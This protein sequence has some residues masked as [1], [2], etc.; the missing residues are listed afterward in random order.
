MSRIW[1]E[2]MVDIE[3]E[4]EF[5]KSGSATGALVPD[6]DDFVEKERLL[7]MVQCIVKW[8]NESLLKIHSELKKIHKWSLF[9]FVQLE[10]TENICGLWK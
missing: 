3:T 4:M 2:G 8:Y 9:F 5:V 6:F 1:A 7:K 10:V